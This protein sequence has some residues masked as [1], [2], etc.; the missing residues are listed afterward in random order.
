MKLVVP[1]VE[2]EQGRLKRIESARYD[3]DGF[4]FEG[5][6]GDDGAAGR[7]THCEFVHSFTDIFHLMN[8]CD[9]TLI[10]CH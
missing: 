7:E 8:E 4:F 5:N 2:Q 9:K 10:Y 6:A 3:A 1:C